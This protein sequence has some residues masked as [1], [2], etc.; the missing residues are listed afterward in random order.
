[1]PWLRSRL[2]S[3]WP[4]WPKSASQLPESADFQKKLALDIEKRRRHKNVV[5]RLHTSVGPRGSSTANRQLPKGF[6][7]IRIAAVLF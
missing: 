7:S 4:R 5:N 6:A 2:T 3:A 1:M